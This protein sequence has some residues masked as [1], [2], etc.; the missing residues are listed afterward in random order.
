M[1]SV[2]GVEKT[3]NLDGTTIA[4][5]GAATVTLLGI[6][7]RVKKNRDFIWT[8]ESEFEGMKPTSY[9][10]NRRSD[11]SKFRF[12]RWGKAIPGAKDARPGWDSPWELRENAATV[13][14]MF[15]ADFRAGKLYIG[16]GGVRIAATDKQQVMNAMMLESKD[17]HQ[18]LESLRRFAW[19]INDDLEEALEEIAMATNSSAQD[20][21]AL[22]PFQLRLVEQAFYKRALKRTWWEVSL[23]PNHNYATRTYWDLL[24]ALSRL[25]TLR[26]IAHEALSRYY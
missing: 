19:G 1:S 18:A 12:C 26:D 11:P 6:S 16:V 10:I 17:I 15:V 24:V 20:L 23:R 8:I 3:K 22:D 5:A 13:K 21:N 4:L 14:E 25:D 9:I 2:D 7:Y